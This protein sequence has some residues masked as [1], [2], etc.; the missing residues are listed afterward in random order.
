M[1]SSDVEGFKEAEI[2]SCGKFLITREDVSYQMSIKV[3]DDN[4]DLVEY[5]LRIPNKI[6]KSVERPK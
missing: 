5:T 2:E 4:N 3:M 1:G 6:I